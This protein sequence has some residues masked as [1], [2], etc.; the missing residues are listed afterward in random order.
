[1]DRSVTIPA[2]PSKSHLH[3]L[4]ICA[5]LADKETTI[6]NCKTEAEDILATTNCLTALG[7]KIIRRGSEIFVTPIDLEN[8]PKSC[9]LPCNESGS[10]LRFMLP[11]VC[12]L[13]VEGTFQMS[14]RLPERPIAPLDT[15]LT[16]HG[17]T[18]SWGQGASRGEL[19][20]RGK[21]VPGDYF[22]PGN[23]TS[24]Y[25]TGLLLALPL[26]GGNS[27]L[28][29]VEPI[30]SEDYIKLA[31]QVIAD[32]GQK[33]SKP[34]YLFGTGDKFISPGIVTAD[35]DWSNAA[36]WLCAGAMLGSGYNIEITGLNLNST[37][38]DRAICNILQEIGTKKDA[39]ID[40]RSIPDLIPP[41]AVVAAVSEGITIIK[42]AE[43]LRL[44][45]SD[46]LMAIAKT[47]NT[48]GARVTE[49]PTGLKIEGVP[50]LMG[51]KTVD[52]FGDH[53]IAMMAAI[54][55]LVCENPITIAG[56]DAVN[57]SYPTFWE[58]FAL[59]K[60]IMDHE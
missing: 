13:G 28:T 18:L 7:A 4:L 29:V 8:L 16:R 35:G 47:L 54:A 44:K 24:Q 55:S 49:L 23:V 41:L 1:M 60:E 45:E 38:G 36:F 43:R 52:A 10:T 27:T 50:K 12:A 59:V 58:D 26:V 21:L 46:R 33:H 22:L 37:Q 6:K 11:I 40:A 31:L 25:I 34:P 56:A 48:L 3:R 14:G 17:I 5:A 42:N 53:R 30:E 19:R 15:E 57:K 9:V 51:G 2:I 39:E 32:F 20:C